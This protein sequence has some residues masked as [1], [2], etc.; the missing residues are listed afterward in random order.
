M[1]PSIVYFTGNGS[2]SII[3][4]I[5]NALFFCESSVAFPTVNVSIP[6]S[7]T[8]EKS[9]V[10]ISA[11]S[12]FIFTF[13]SFVSLDFLESVVFDSSVEFLD[14]LVSFVAFSVE[15][16]LSI[17]LVLL[18]S[19]ATFSFTLFWYS[20]VTSLNFLVP[21]LSNSIPI[22]NEDVLLFSLFCCPNLTDLTSLLSSKTSPVSLSSIV[23]FPISVKSERIISVLSSSG[24]SITI[25]PE[26]SSQVIL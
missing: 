12:I 1:F 10:K 5:F 19:F 20:L 21:L 11:S 23:N 26:F 14:E 4:P 16:V 22:T 24:I 15:F 9:V 2:F 6:L 7:I 17:E 3:A 13:L 18:V 8:S 25:L